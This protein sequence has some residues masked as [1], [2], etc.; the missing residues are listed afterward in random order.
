MV[1]Q[2]QLV[3][4]EEFEAF[5]DARVAEGDDRHYELIDGEIVEKM[6]TEEHGAIGVKLILRIGM[7]NEAHSLGRLTVEARHRPP[8]DQHNDRIPDISFTR[9][10][11]LLPLT[12]KGAVP[13]MPDLA[14]EIQS[15]SNSIKVM[16]EKAAF[17]LANG[18]MLVW[19]IITSKS[20]IEVHTTEV[21]DIL[22]GD[23]MLDGGE[24]LPGFAV[25]VREIFEVD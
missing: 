22:T 23:E 2:E 21:I 3:T 25:P 20:L 10:E 18:V 19:L 5:L 15:P 9:K 6:P 17:Y 8:E 24:V 1:L 16:R 4:R 14:V 11:R 12:K 7:F 13:Q